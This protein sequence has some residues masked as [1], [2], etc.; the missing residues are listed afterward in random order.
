MLYEHVLVFKCTVVRLEEVQW[1]PV[2]RAFEFR[3]LFSFYI[4]LMHK[5]DEWNWNASRMP[6]GRRNPRFSRFET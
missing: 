4:G 5:Q 2:H 1:F 3:A 6:K